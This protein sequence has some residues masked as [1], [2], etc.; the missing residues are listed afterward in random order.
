VNVAER[1]IAALDGAQAC[2]LFSSGM[3]AVT[4][5][6]LAMLR[7]GQHI[8]MTDES[9]RRTRQFVSKLLGRFGVAHSI[10]PVGDYH[11]LEA[12]VRPGETRV[13]LAESPTNP[14]LNVED[15]DALREVARRHRVKTIIDSTFATPVNQQPARWGIDL[16]LHSATKYLAG[17]NDLLAGSVSGKEPIIAAIKE[18]RDVVGSVLGAHS[19]YLLIRGMKTLHLRVARQNETALALA[20]FLEAHPHV[21]RV[22]Y[23][24]LE[25]HPGHMLATGQMR[26]FGG[27]VSFELDA[28]LEGTSR[29]IDACR[30]AHIAPSLGGVETLIEQPALMS[31]YELSTEERK[32]VG[33]SD[34][35][36]R[37]SVGVEDGADLRADLERAL[38]AAL[39]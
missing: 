7:S 8:V 3:A 23:P 6:L 1:K 32:A 29:F 2:A 22:Y 16:V 10:V 37:M 39:G 31:F 15:L 34:N 28:D 33:I 4:T 30:L 19:A 25:S 5:T 35:L 13:I 11:A 12:A 21:R 26:G 20:R 17:H 18:F 38:G 24:G 27:V 14:Y 36:V 9:Y